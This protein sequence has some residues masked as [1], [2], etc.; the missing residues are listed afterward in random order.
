M[1]IDTEKYRFTYLYLKVTSV[2]S[3]FCVFG[4]CNLNNIICNMNTNS[5][6]LSN[7]HNVLWTGRH[8][9]QAVTVILNF[10]NHSVSIKCV[11]GRYVQQ[12]LDE[13]YQIGCQYK[14]LP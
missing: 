12:I 5:A 7:V 1:K 3:F 11:S 4:Y 10:T 9:W 2:L 13:F 8:G 6:V 14:I